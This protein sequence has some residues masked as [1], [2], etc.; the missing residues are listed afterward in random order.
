MLRVDNSTRIFPELSSP[1][2]GVEIRKAERPMKTKLEAA[3]CFWR[4]GILRLKLIAVKCYGKWNLSIKPNFSFAVLVSAGQDDTRLKVSKVIYDWKLQPP[5]PRW[6][7]KFDLKTRHAEQK[8]K[9]IKNAWRGYKDPINLLVQCPTQTQS[10]QNNTPTCVMKSAIYY[11]VF[12]L[13]NEKLPFAVLKRKTRET[14][15]PK[16]KI[17]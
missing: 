17:H 6:D 4:R 1:V 9:G 16:S 15:S 3:S 12:S 14:F 2:C 5:F 13:Q 7:L 11:A 10:F 8:L